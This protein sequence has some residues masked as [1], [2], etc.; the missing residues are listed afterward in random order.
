[1][2]IEKFTKLEPYKG[3][4]KKSDGLEKIFAELK[5]NKKKPKYNYHSGLV[6]G[7]IINTL[8]TTRPIIEANKKQDRDLLQHIFENMMPMIQGLV[9]DYNWN[10]LDLNNLTEQFFGSEL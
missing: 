5:Y 8:T 6:A 10:L 3:I 9:K 4:Q 1:M 7:M 2:S